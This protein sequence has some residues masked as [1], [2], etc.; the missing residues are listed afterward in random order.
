MTPACRAPE[1]SKLKRARILAREEWP[2]V[3]AERHLVGADDLSHGRLG[4]ASRPALCGRTRCA[5]RWHFCWGS[6]ELFWMV[7]QSYGRKGESPLGL[8]VPQVGGRRIPPACQAAFGPYL[9]RTSAR[10]SRMPRSSWA[11]VRS[12]RIRCVTRGRA[13][14]FTANMLGARD[15]RPQHG[16][17]RLQARVAAGHV[18]P[19]LTMTG[20]VV[21]ELFGGSR[22]FSHPV[23]EKGSGL[24][25]A[26]WSAGPARTSPG[27][28]CGVKSRKQCTQGGL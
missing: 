27:V 12:C 24:G 22:R 6:G 8:V 15:M 18:P 19:S 28:A 11:S 17:H 26:T 9:T 7:P 16:R 14:A 3:G 4:V 23:A 1:F 13:P 5:W 10:A 25:S 21:L 2:Q 20:E